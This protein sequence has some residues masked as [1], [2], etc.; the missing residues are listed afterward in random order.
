MRNGSRQCRHLLY[1]AAI[2]KGIDQT[3][4]T[5]SETCSRVPEGLGDSIILH[6]NNALAI[7]RPAQITRISRNADT[8]ARSIAFLI[9]AAISTSVPAGTANAASLISLE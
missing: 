2:R 8:K 1:Y 9:A 4:F 3:L 5:P 6:A 7:D